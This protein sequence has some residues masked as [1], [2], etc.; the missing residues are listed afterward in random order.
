MDTRHLRLVYEADSDPPEWRQLTYL[1][2]VSLLADAL[3]EMYS[4]LPDSQR[5]TL[6]SDTFA[7]G[8]TLVPQLNLMAFTAIRGLRQLHGED[9][10]AFEESVATPEGV[11]RFLHGIVGEMQLPYE[12]M[13]PTLLVITI[14]DRMRNDSPPTAS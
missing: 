2:F 5:A 6:H 3:V 12:Q 4:D 9:S 1:R 13:S 7:D 14:D 8:V 10:L 11:R